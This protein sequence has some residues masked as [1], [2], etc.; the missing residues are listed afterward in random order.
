MLWQRRSLRPL[1]VRQDHRD[2]GISRG[3]PRGASGATG[4]S[5]KTDVARSVL[6]LGDR[7]KVVAG[8]GSNNTAHSVECAKAA[9]KFGIQV[10]SMGFLVPPDQAV[11]W[12]GPML[13][14]AITQFLRDTLW[15]PLDYL[16][17]DMPPGT[18]DIALTLSQLLPL[19]GA[20]VVSSSP[21]ASSSSTAR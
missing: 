6:E 17:I 15:G 4:A 7:A 8:V 16:I 21:W 11:V 19:T 10:I 13:H 3:C 5:G 18:G 12:R 20:V 2:E 1:A 14:G 9:E